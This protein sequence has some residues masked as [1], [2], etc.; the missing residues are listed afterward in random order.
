MALD[1]ITIAG[2]VSELDT[3]ITGG[4]ITKIAQPEKDELL[5]TIKQSKTDEDG[6]TVRSQYRLTISVNPSLPLIY[7]ND[8]N[9]QSPMQA[10]TFCMVLRKHLNNCR[11][12]G[13]SQIGLERV[14]KFELQHLNEMG[15]LCKKFLIVELMGKHSN[16]IFCDEDNKIIDSIKHISLLVSSV[17]EVL[18]GREYFIPNTQ[19]KFDPFT[20]SE[21]EFT[22]VILAKP[23]TPAK[24]LYTSL[25]G[26]SPVMANELLYIASLS[27]RNSAQDMTEMEK[28]HLYRN[29]RKIMEKIE[30]KEFI[31]NSI[32]KGSSCTNAVPAEFACILLNMYEEDE[33]YSIKRCESVSSMLYEYYATKEIVS[34]IKQK[35]SDLRR[36]TT[37]ALE[38]ARKK[39]DLQEKQLKD[40]DK[41]DKYKVYGELLTTY[42]YE[43]KGGEKSLTCDN[44]YTNEKVTIPLDETKSAVDNAKRYFE[45]YA[46]LKRTFEAMTVQTAETKEEI[47]HLESISNALDIARYEEDLT[48]IK[49]ELTEYGYI[50]R[51]G[52]RGK[53]SKK[54]AKSKPMHY[55]SSDGFDMYVGKNNYQNDE[56]T[57]KIATG[58]DWWFH[59]KA[60]A[61]SH[62]IVKTEGKELPDRTFEEAARLAAYYSKAKEQ[63]KA[64][65]DYIQKKH[66]KKPNG[67]KPGFVVYYTN[68]SMTIDTDISG[69]KEVTE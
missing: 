15:D 26:F 27:D 36:I 25:T 22:E 55:I 38:R 28:I 43:L 10:P 49:R 62:V 40:T 12:T 18:P 5:L 52:D 29:F 1:G 13:I 19:E 33:A 11:I 17:R 35:S 7:L 4:R 51:H 9:K 30:N 6:N 50:K 31:P 41:R 37:T 42:G 46:K 24:A 16:I 39:Y 57:F 21:S 23:V 58:N 48:A 20:V 44:Y 59:A 47:E 63:G 3:K 65:I 56:L 32:Y 45:K 64:E 68:Y 66:V 69:I 53:G 14:I 60:S 34:R 54:T 2:M 61:G 8:D 67:S